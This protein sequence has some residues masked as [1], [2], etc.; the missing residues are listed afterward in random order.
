MAAPDGFNRR[1]DMFADQVAIH[2]GRVAF[3]D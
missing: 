1:H 2:A 3:D